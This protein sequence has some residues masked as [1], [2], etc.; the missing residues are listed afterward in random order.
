[1]EETKAP[2]RYLLL[3]SEISSARNG[4]YLPKLLANGTPWKPPCSSDYCQGCW[5]FSTNWKQKTALTYLI[6]YREVEPGHMY[7]LGFMVLEGTLHAIREKA[8]H[9]PSYKPYNL[10]GD[11]P[12]WHTGARV[13][14]IWELPIKLSNLIL[15]PTTWEGTLSDIVWVT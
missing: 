6:E 1:M 10:N 2:T 9:W 8:K 11:L 13:E 5:L 14:K 4:L 12:A 15:R 7:C 3:P